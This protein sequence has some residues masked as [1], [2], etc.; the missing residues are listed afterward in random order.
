[1]KNIKSFDTIGGLLTWII[2]FT[3][4][5]LFVIGYGVGAHKKKS[6]FI[7]AGGF[8]GGKSVSIDWYFLVIYICFFFVN[9]WKNAI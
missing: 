5:E 7:G 2:I 1:M 4:V 3:V 9:Y 8:R 6:P